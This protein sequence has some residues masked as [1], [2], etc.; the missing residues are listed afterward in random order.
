MLAICAA[1]LCGC[2]DLRPPRGVKPVARTLLVTGYCRC[3]EC[4][5]WR[6]TW[7]G[8]PVYASGPLRGRTKA[9]GIT[10]TGT[11]A[12]WGTIAADTTRYPFGTILYVPGYGLGRVED[13]GGDIKGEHIDLYFMSHRQAQLWGARKMRVNV[14]FLRPPPEATPHLVPAGPTPPAAQK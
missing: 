3:G 8:R 4:C 2:D 6:R 14:W 10:A 7:Y 1:L 5:G 11:R 9:I 12:R 13:V